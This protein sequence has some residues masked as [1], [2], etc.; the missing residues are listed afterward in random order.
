MELHL[1]FPL[2][3]SVLFVIGILFAKKAISG[4][5]TPW[6][7]TF[8]SNVALGAAWGTIGAARNEWL[9]LELWPCA[10]LIG[11]AFVAGQLFTYL[12]YQ[13]GDVSVATPILGVKVVMV[14]LLLSLLAGET[15]GANV[16]WGAVL[17]T[18]GV[19]TVQAGGSRPDG[20]S[21]VG[22]RQASLTVVLA[23]MS[24]L[25]LS[26]FDVGLQVWGRRSGGTAFLTAVFI[27]TGVL[28]FGFLPWVD[29]PRRLRELDVLNPLL[30]GSAVMTLQAMSISYALGAY[31][32][33][34]RINIVYALRG[35]WAVGLAWL[36]GRK[37][38]GAEAS[39][40]RG[41]MLL[42]LAGAVLLTLAVVIALRD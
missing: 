33:A 26:L 20:L 14:A 16:W 24:A 11:A 4:G 22:A 37:F 39:H 41:V 32:D 12:A 38:G 25:A 13:M 18:A 30:V 8:V 40:S 27:S 36:L 9:P 17:A 2:A 19:A 34:A 5:A 6:T 29:R 7:N 35:L 3:S 23:L 10:A 21:R 1:L 15:V 31:G 42:R 28:S